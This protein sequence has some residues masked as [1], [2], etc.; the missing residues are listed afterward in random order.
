LHSTSHSTYHSNTTHNKYITDSGTSVSLSHSE[1][2]TFVVQDFTMTATP[3]TITLN[4]G[5][6]GTST[7]TIAPLNGFTGTVNLASNSTACTLSPTSV[8]TSGSS[9]LSCTFTAASTIHV[10]VTGTSGIISHSVTVTFIVRDFTIAASPSSVSY[11][12]G[13]AATSTI[14]I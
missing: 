1:T 5:T 6:A 9:T 11:T 10:T 3:T 4:A 14:T 12:P 13:T 8:T 2:I 7:I